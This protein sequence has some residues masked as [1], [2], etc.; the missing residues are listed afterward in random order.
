LMLI[1][2]Q[3]LI[4][5]RIRIRLFT[6]MWKRIRLLKTWVHANPD[7]QDVL[8]ASVSKVTLNLFDKKKPS[9][10]SCGRFLTKELKMQKSAIQ[11]FLHMYS[12]LRIRIRGIRCLFDPG[13]R[14]G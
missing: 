4:S 12:V 8:Y 1:F 11:K 2:I 7:P 9:Q 10:I 6:L 13:I 5:M 3:L 14:E